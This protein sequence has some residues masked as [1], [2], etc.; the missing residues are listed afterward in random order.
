MKEEKY[1]VKISQESDVIFRKHG[2]FTHLQKFRLP[3]LL[4]TEPMLQE[5]NSPLVDISISDSPKET[6]EGRTGGQEVVLCI[7]NMITFQLC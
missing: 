1:C 2:Q 5:E 4:P 7:D 6:K 3:I